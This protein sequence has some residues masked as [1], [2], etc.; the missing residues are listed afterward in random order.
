MVYLG[1]G[2]R[3][4]DL[5]MRFYHILSVYDNATPALWPISSNVHAVQTIVRV[6]QKMLKCTASCSWRHDRDYLHIPRRYMQNYMNIEQKT[7]ISWILPQKNAFIP[8]I[9]PIIDMTQS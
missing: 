6:Y 3:Y 7:E 5:T 9:H 8:W 4:G 1:Q 2:K